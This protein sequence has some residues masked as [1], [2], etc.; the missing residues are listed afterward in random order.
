MKWLIPYNPVF[1]LSVEFD[2]FK[3]HYDAD[4]YFVLK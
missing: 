2:C 1:E 4:I 3:H